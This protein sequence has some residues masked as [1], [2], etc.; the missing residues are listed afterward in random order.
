MDAFELFNEKGSPTG[1]WCCGNCRKLVL[2]QTFTP[3]NAN[4]PKSDRESAEACCRPQFCTKCQAE[5]KTDRLRK[6]MFCSDCES[7]AWREQHAAR[8]QER[9]EKA[10]LVTDYDGPLYLDGYSGDWGD[11]YHSDLEHLV[12]SIADSEYIY[13]DEGRLD[14]DSIPEFAFCCTTEVKALDLDHAIENLCEDG[15][16]DMGD[17]LTIPPL[18]NVA[19][20]LFN[21]INEK[22]LTCYNQDMKHKVAIRQAVIDYVTQDP[23]I[24]VVAHGDQN[25]PEQV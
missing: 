7:A 19:V 3:S 8:E 2:S 18:L 21:R 15:Y 25:P 14:P 22:S 1:V 10:E 16:E 24:G 9:L 13:D 6:Q 17:R 4:A 11:A 20:E 5:L 12:E 23:A